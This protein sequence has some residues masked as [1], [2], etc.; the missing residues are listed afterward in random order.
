MPVTGISITSKNKIFIN[1]KNGKRI[2]KLKG[3]VEIPNQIDIRE[4]EGNQRTEKIIG[5]EQEAEV[6]KD[7][8]LNKLNEE[9]QEQLKSLMAKLNE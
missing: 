8:P 4:S 1:G 9:E 2:T 7:L 6:K 3:G 5:S